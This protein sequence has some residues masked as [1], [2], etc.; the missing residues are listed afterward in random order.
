MKKINLLITTIVLCNLLVS[1]QTPNDSVVRRDITIEREYN[2]VIM[3][4]KKVNQTL[5][6]AEPNVEKNKV[7]Y[8]QFTSPLTLTSPSAVL[9]QAPLTAMARDNFKNGH[10]KLAIGLPL[11]WDVEL[12]YPLVNKKN[13]KLDFDFKNNGLFW[14]WGKGNQT[15]TTKNTTSSLQ[16]KKYIETDINLNFNHYFD[17]A[18]LYLD[19]GYRNKT[20]NRYGTTQI[21]DTLS[22]I[23]PLDSS[24]ILGKELIKKD[25]NL[26]TILAK[27]GCRAMPTNKLIYDANINYGLFFMPQGFSEHQFGINTMFDFMLKD[28]DYRIA[29]DFGMNNLLYGKMKDGVANLPKYSSTIHFSPRFLMTKKQLLLRAGI[30]TAFAIKRE[31][32]QVANI[33]PDVEIEYFINPKMVSIYAGVGGGFELNSLREIYNQ[34]CFANEVEMLP[35]TYTPADFYAGVKVKPITFFFIDAYVHYKLIKNQYFFVNQSYSLK[36]DVTDSRFS[37]C[38]NTEFY[39]TDLLKVGLN[40]NYNYKEKFSASIKAQ[41]NGWFL[42]GEAKTAGEK[43]WQRPTWELNIGGDYNITPDIRFAASYYLAAERYAKMADGSALKMRNIHDINLSVSYSYSSWLSAY[44]QVNNMLGLAPKLR[45]QNWYG[46]DVVGS[47]M[48]GVVFSF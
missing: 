21:F 45:Y 7:E 29:F 3:D 2:P 8:S 13:S 25:G 40:L 44:L 28:K 31:K 41:Y 27:I 33:S 36:N 38:F 35:D 5:P 14:D 37:N 6:I 16:R 26:N 39:D 47:I 32:T 1:A 11:K 46:Y 18:N 10:A 12:A 48:A 23:N 20:F 30:K 42:K 24:T 19:L 9:P 4:A 15:D 17:N 34:N 22:F 43:A